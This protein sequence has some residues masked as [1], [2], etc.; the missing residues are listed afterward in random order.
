V[1]RILTIV[2]F[3]LLAKNFRAQ[4]NEGYGVNLPRFYK[5]KIHFG[6]TIAFNQTDF[7]LNT[8]KNSLFPDTLIRT[9]GVDTRYTI[10]SVYTRPGP[11]FAIGLVTDVRLHNYVRL[12]TTPSISFAS[13][14][15]EYYMSNRSRDTSKFFEKTV[16]STFLIFPAELKIQSKR[17]DNFSAYVIGGGGYML[18]LASR[19]KTAGVSSGGANQLNDNIKLKRD[20]FYYSGGAGVD[21]YLMY[22]KL[23]FELKLHM[24]TINLLRAENSVFSNSLEKVR[25]R[26]VTFT[27]TFEG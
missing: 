15:I 7:R 6:F 24:G 22:F 14:K 16:E 25:S 19:K 26:M 10:K 18:D 8:V 17:L 13:R 12:R 11:G 23:G 4:E 3:L 1:N 27:V 5:Q 9:A 21:F 20:D 2:L